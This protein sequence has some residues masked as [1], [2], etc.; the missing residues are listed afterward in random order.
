MD[1]DTDEAAAER[2]R[3]RQRALG[4]TPEEHAAL[5]AALARRRQRQGRMVHHTPAEH[6]ALEETLARRRRRRLAEVDRALAAHQRRSEQLRQERSEQLRQRRERERE[7]AAKVVEKER[8]A[9]EEMRVA[10]EELRRGRQHDH[11]VNDYDAE[12]V[13]DHCEDSDEYAETSHEGP[14][15]RTL[16]ENWMLLQQP[17]PQPRPQQ[18]RVQQ[19]RQQQHEEQ[20]KR[21]YHSGFYDALQRMHELIATTDTHP[22]NLPP[23]PRG[24]G[25]G[26]PAQLRF[27]RKVRGAGWHRRGY[28]DFGS[29]WVNV[30]DGSYGH[31][32][33]QDVEE[34]ITLQGFVRQVFSMWCFSCFLLPCLTLFSCFPSP[35]PTPTP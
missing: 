12:D 32:R 34:N 25:S 2:R 7:A 15:A 30:R 14:D 13:Y 22:T 4:R 9:A 17:H 24:P 6:A 5:E 33:G 31:T 26:A 10:E 23:P 1:A 18:Q 11:A 21:Q 3:Y 35:P 20:Q 19:V 29:M 8:I 16:Y 28:R 27:G